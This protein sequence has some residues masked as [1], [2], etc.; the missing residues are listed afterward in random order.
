[1]DIKVN[2]NISKEFN[3]TIIKI[4]VTAPEVTE[5]IQKFLNNISQITKK[6]EEI[7]ATKNN[8]IFLLKSKNVFYFYSDEKNNFAKTNDGI[9]KIKEKLYEL[10][11]NLD[12]KK[13][14]R[15]SNSCIINIDKTKCFDVSQIGSLFAKMED[16][17]KQEVT[18]RKIKNVMNF[19]NERK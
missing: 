3:D 2:T 13:F 17:T 4:E 10:E 9:Y 7:V 6:K 16:D 14:I 18:K 8:E 1:M 11:E 19:L 12:E 5:D 15:I